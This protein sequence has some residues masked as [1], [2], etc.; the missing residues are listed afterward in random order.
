MLARSFPQN[1]ETGLWRKLCLCQRQRCW[2]RLRAPAKVVKKKATT[3]IINNTATL[4]KKDT[5]L[6]NVSKHEVLMGLDAN[7]KLAGHSD[8]FREGDAVL[9][10][11]MTAGDE[12]RA[13][14]FVNVMS[15]NGLVA[16][17]TWTA[18]AALQGEMYTKESGTN[19]R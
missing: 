18:A 8:G 11:D 12:E 2:E 5:I 4:D 7:A 15:K 10:S 14:L 9:N 17:N 19:K 13:T 1:R 6:G 3:A 16:Q